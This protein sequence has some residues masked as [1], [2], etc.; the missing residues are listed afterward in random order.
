MSQRL[1]RGRTSPAVLIL[2]SVV[3]AA[4]VVAV[5]WFIW[6]AKPQQETRQTTHAAALRTFGLAN[7]VQNK[8]AD[9]FNDAD[10][11]YVADPPTDP[12]DFVDPP[13]LF[14]SYVALEDPAPYQAAFADFVDHLAKVTGK[15]VE[16]LPVTGT[17]DQLKAL[18]DGQLH[19][20]GFNTGSVPIA[21]YLCGF[22]PAFKLASPDGVATLQTQIIVPADSPMRS[23]GDLKG[24]EL[25]LT[26]PNSNAGYKAPV[27]L[28]RRQFGL[29]PERDYIP[30]FSMEY[31]R[32]IQGIADKELQAAAIASDVLERAVTRG[33]ISTG[34][35]RSIYTSE[36]FPTACFGY[37]HN[38]KPELAAKVRE[39]FQTF[40]WQ[41]TSLEK[42]FAQSNQSRFVPVS[43]KDDWALVRL[44][45]DQ[46]GNAYA[47][48]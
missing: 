11:D 1:S 33:D 2:V 41:G 27:V 3:P 31:D 16:Y 23:P 43:F 15:K 9:R 46:I 18:R 34:Q 42:E 47:L 17:N 19:V 30:R 44:I 25:S 8:L 10:H 29:E 38:L 24:R 7:P 45:D 6:V 4:V 14:F 22:T 28:L 26:E 39:A 12:K 35:F 5:L 37:A 21:V 32:S 13:V 40:Q 48:D 20:T 36:S